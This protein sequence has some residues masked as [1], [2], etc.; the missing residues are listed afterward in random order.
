LKKN[1]HF[2]FKE[3]KG[4]KDR[5]KRMASSCHVL[6]L[7]LYHDSYPY[8]SMID[9]TRPFYHRFR[10]MGVETYYYT[11]DPN[12][13]DITVEEDIVYIPGHESFIP[14]ILDKTIRVIEF[15]SQT[16]SFDYILRSNTSTVINFTPLLHLLQT[17]TIIYGSC[18]IMTTNNVTKE[19]GNVDA[20]YYPLPFAH[21]VSIILHHTAVQL[22]LK[23][24][25][26][27]LHYDTIDDIS[28][29]MFFKDHNITPQQ[30]GAQYAGIF[31]HVNVDFATAFRNRNYDD[32]ERKSDVGKVKLE[33]DILT[34]RHFFIREKR[35]L[36]KKVCYHEQDITAF[37]IVL[38]KQLGQWTTDCANIKLDYLFGDPKPNT[39]KLLHVY[40]ED[41]D[42]ISQAANWTFVFDRMEKQLRVC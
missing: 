33:V 40:L 26:T 36:V 29:G 1:F 15:F 19:D 28:L 37:I 9:I 41:G 3:V 5:E 4:K 42:I 20:R 39:L 10:E 8:N 14:G 23:H 12:V 25:E 7:V 38:C 30:V 31:P 35:P 32:P 18:L 27:H 24:K 6:H 21:G 34:K 17:H 2:V 16:K 22:L 11:F 13:K